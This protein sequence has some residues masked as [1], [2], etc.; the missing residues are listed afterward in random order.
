MFDEL[1][2]EKL[3]EEAAKITGEEETTQE[4]ATEETS[5]EEKTEETQSR[6]E[7]SEDTTSIKSEEETQETEK[8]TEED[9][10]FDKH[11]RWIKLRER[12]E[13]AEE[14]AKVANA[15]EEKLGDLPIEELTRLRN[16]GSL[17]R[18]YPELATKVQKVIDEH[19]YVNEETKGEIDAIRQETAD[20]RYDLALDKYDKVVDKLIS[21]NKVDKDIEPLVK[22]VLENR[23]IN[24]KLDAKDIPQAFEKALKDVNLAYRKKLASHIETKKSETKVPASPAQKGKVIVTKSEATDVGSVV[25]EL[26]EGLKAHR[27]EPIKE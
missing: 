7:T 3:V 6:E 20:L 16:A 4:T 21:E 12:A 8:E 11:P 2:T 24:Q 23:V 27:G 9:T 15:L 19:T 5:T 1:D 13:T 14:R 26:A 25:N 18:K 17:L 22:E 10:R